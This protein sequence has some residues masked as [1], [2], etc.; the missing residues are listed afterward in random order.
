VKFVTEHAFAF[1]KTKHSIKI[2]QIILLEIHVGLHTY[3]L[4]NSWQ[5]K[6]EDK[7]APVGPPVGSTI[8]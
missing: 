2:T 3:I 8:M 1:D 5:G 4:W 7:L 6:S